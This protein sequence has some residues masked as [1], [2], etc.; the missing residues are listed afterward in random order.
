LERHANISQRRDVLERHAN[1]DP[2]CGRPQQ[3]EQ[4]SACKS[5]D[6]VPKPVHIGNKTVSACS[7]G[8]TDISGPGVVP[9]GGTKGWY[10]AVVPRGGTKGWYQ[11]VVP[12]G[13]TKGWYRG[14]VPRGS[15]LHRRGTPHQWHGLA[16]SSS[17]LEFAT[18][19]LDAGGMRRFTTD[20][21]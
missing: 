14:V 16:A 3:T 1:N 6:E 8:S 21:R 13:G 4:Q 17:A 15:K 9:R 12:R 19:R 11:G 18:L 2:K 7:S 10:Q 20:K 5:D